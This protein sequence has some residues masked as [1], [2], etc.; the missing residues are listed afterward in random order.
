M[1]WWM[2]PTAITA[3]AL[4]WPFWMARDDRGLV[5]GA[6]WGMCMLPALAVIAITWLVAAVLK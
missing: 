3:L 4:Y 6:V 5:G 1:S 2:V